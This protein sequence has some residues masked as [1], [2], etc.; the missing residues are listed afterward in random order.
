MESVRYVKKHYA[1]LL[2]DIDNDPFYERKEGDDG[3]TCYHCTNCEQVTKTK[4]LDVGV[5]PFK[6]LCCHCG[7]HTATRTMVDVNPEQDVDVLW[8]RPDIHD[9]IKL[10]KDPMVLEHVLKGGL[11]LKDVEE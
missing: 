11:L 2:I 10:R 5:I 9:C 6:I 1:K 3:I 4:K 8:Y 7:G